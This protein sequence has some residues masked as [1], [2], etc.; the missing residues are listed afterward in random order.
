MTLDLMENDRYIALIIGV[1]MLAGGI[2]LWL[3]SYSLLLIMGGVVLS[4]AGII[5]IR[6]KRKRRIQR[7]RLA[8]G[9]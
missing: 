5:Q 9:W 3:F 2:I 6:E 1:L 7:E 4:A 8:R